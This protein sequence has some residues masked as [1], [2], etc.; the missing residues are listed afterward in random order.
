MNLTVNQKRLS[1][2]LAVALVGLLIDQF[3]GGPAPVSATPAE[4]LLVPRSGGPAAEA[5]PN[6][7]DIPNTARIEKSR[8]L[9]SW[10]APGVQTRLAELSTA[11]AEPGTGEAVRSDP[12]RVEQPALVQIPTSKPSERETT[13]RE[14]AD[15]FA[16]SHQ[17][18]AVIGSGPKGVVLISDRMVRMGEGLEGWRL[19]EIGSTTAVF[20][21]AGFRVRFGLSD[22]PFPQ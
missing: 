10:G 1:A 15:T 7:T 9:R 2:V 6:G 14:D 18:R 4:S 8:S 21:K 5:R 20:E 17:L 22:V 12:F 16:A 19:V 11:T 3:I 13:A